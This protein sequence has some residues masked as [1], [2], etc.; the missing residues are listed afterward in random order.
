MINARNSGNPVLI[1]GFQEF[2]RYLIDD[3]L[4][5]RGKKLHK[6]DF[7]LLLIL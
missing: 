5:E 3:F 2:Y 1:C 7:V 4:I 6:K